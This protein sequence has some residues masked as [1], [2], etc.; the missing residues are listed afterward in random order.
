[1]LKRAAEDPY[2][3]PVPL[4]RRSVDIDPTLRA[5]WRSAE[6]QLHQRQAISSPAPSQ[7]PSAA[8]DAFS[9]LTADDWYVVFFFLYT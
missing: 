2:A 7:Q 9:G 5:E 1:M 8:V 4:K 6:P 3:P